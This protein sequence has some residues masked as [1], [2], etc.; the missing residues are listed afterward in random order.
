MAALCFLLTAAC[1]C[2]YRKKKIPNY[3]IVVMALT[4]VVWQF[5]M[6]GPMGAA[7]A[8]F[9]MAL[10]GSILYPLFKI[11]A[12]GAGDVKLFGVTAGCL[13]FDKILIF[14]FV[15]LL[16]AAIISLVKLWKNGN[17]RERVHYFLEYMTDVWKNGSW[18]L[19]LED[20]MDS[21]DIRLCLSGPVLLSLLLYLGG[22]Y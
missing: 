17:F 11:G 2:D 10:I 12:M 3:L 15:S 5:L 19:Y 8:V 7:I 21:S 18:Q 13:P 22:A 1:Y 9:Q 14:L 4:G 20:G 16:I 6:T